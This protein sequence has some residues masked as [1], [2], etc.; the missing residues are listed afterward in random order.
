MLFVQSGEPLDAIVA[1]TSKP[2]QLRP[3]KALNRTERGRPSQTLLSELNGA[4]EV[5]ATI[6]FIT[7]NER[8][9]LS[10]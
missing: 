4:Q 10:A 9:A 2:R 8:R 6:L 5:P 7:E 1:A 3:S